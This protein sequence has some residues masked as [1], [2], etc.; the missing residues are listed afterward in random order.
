[1]SERL[2][3]TAASVLV[4]IATAIVVLSV[5]IVPFLSPAWVTFEQGRSEAAAWTGYSPSQL[6]AAT[7]AIL[8]D[9]VFGPPNFDVQVNG[10]P[11]LN[12]RERGHMADVRRVFVGLAILAVASAVLLVVAGLLRTGRLARPV[13]AGVAGLATGV[14]AVGLIGAFAFDL[15]F[16]VFHRLFFAGGTYTFDPRTDRLVQLFPERF[17][18]ET[19]MAVGV[20]ILLLC[21]GVWWLAGRRTHARSAEPAAAPAALEPGR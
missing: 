4:A 1:V 10:T 16:E 20:L 6:Q 14:V 8:S 19:S 2:G 17:W 3:R 15:A 11:V 18:F 12:A 13:R 21:A 7:G 9:L 5:A